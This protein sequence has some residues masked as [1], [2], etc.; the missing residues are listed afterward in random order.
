M[1]SVIGFGSM[2]GL[3]AGGWL[4]DARPF[5]FSMRLLYAALCAIMV[6]W[7]VALWVAVPGSPTTAAMTGIVIFWTSAALI[8]PSLAIEKALVQADPERS[9]LTLAINTSVIYLGQGLGSGLGG[10]VVA[11]LGYGPLG[12][13]GGAIAGIAL[14]VACVANPEWSKS[15]PRPR[16]PKPRKNRRVQSAKNG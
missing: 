8:A 14:L 6:L 10:G 1:Q 12:W 9:S 15:D 5:L 7:S 4:A 11:S 3:L 13:V 16:S 2:A